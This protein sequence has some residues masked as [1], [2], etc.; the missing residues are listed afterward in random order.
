M[1]GSVVRM[2]EAAADPGLPAP[3][4]IEDLVPIGRGG[5]ATVYRGWQ[6]AL[7]REVAVKV[8]DVVPGTPSP[9][10]FEKEL[11]AVGTLSGHPHVVPVYEA[12]EME[13]RPY[14]VMPL[15]AGGTL[16]DRMA[17]GPLPAADTVAVGCAIADALR[18]AHGLGV[19]HRDVKP[20]NILFP[21]YGEAQLADFGIA[22]F[23][24]T[25]ATHGQLNATVCYAAPEVL[26]GERSTPASD[27]YSLGATLHA[28]LRGA[29]P[30]RARDG[31]SVVAFA[32]RVIG[33]EPADLLEAGVPPALAAVVA[34][35]MAKDPAQRF[36]SVAA[37]EAALRAADLRGGGAGGDLRGAPGAADLRGAPSVQPPAPRP[38]GAA[39]AR[40]GRGPDRVL[41]VGSA[42]AVLAVVATALGLAFASGHRAPPRSSATPPTSAP[43]AAKAP[44]TTAR[45]APAPA[46]TAPAKPAAAHPAEVSLTPASLTS[47]VDEYYQLVDQHQL[48][49]SF[50]WLTPAFRARIGFD[51]YQQ[52]WNS[53][54][55]VDVLGVTPGSGAATVNLRYV[56]TDG[57]TSVEQ[58]ALTFTPD[59]ASGHL[60]IDQRGVG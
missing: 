3:A 45:A 31:E 9:A 1:G 59:P 27:L 12:G 16:E 15:L 58:A 54:A 29:P 26:T 37:F 49:R 21:A 41:L 6:G 43:H 8:L 36:V 2:A 48:A 53:I 52:F 47:T 38:A 39:R 17:P 60:L 14:L 22:H 46:T 28:A 24:D 35:A 32:V 44:P 57:D 56:K 40:L 33:E 34:R 50:G 5:S 55:R 25:T 4:G 23:A 18:A 42:V 10:R 13:G 19:L 7:H 20:A 30:F 51:Y 11:R